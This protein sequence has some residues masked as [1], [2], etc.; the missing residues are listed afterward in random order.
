MTFP[1]LP[2]RS[3]ALR[4]MPQLLTDPSLPCRGSND[5]SESPATQECHVWH[6]TAVGQRRPLQLLCDADTAAI[7]LIQSKLI[8]GGRRGVTV[9]GSNACCTQKHSQR[10]IARMIFSDK[11]G[12]GSRVYY[13][14]VSREAK[15]FPAI[16]G[17]V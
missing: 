6:S 17:Q 1:N 8:F 14:D 15:A 16:E 4:S 3:N 7:A 12:H 2:S 10:V 13:V 11:K 9:C 5:L